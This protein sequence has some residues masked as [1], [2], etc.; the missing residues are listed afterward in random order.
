MATA[1]VSGLRAALKSFWAI[2]RVA[3][4]LTLAL[5]L[6][7]RLGVL[8]WV[9]GL[10]KP[11]MNL[12]GLPGEA[13]LA[14]LASVFCNTY[15]AAAV[16]LS[17]PLDLRT[18]TILAVMVLTAHNVFSESVAMKRTGSSATKMILMRL[19]Y[20]CAAA[21]A[22]KLLLPSYLRYSVF[23]SVAAGP[24]PSF[25]GMLAAWARAEGILAYKLALLLVAVSLAKAYLSE[26]DALGPLSRL[27]A[28]A[29]R[30]LGLSRDA[31][32]P[33]VASQVIG[34]FRSAEILEAQVKSGGL[35]PQESDLVNHCT[36][37]CHSL[38]EE[39]LLFGLLG[40]PLFW[41]TVPR[42]CMA[43]VPVWFERL[44]RRIFRRSFR[45]GTV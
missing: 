26:F 15:V 14:L 43:L 9:S 28:P 38:L 12:L 44:R 36:A 34:Y 35:K 4:P 22:F 3:I 24:R 10:A 6:L 45:V 18:A 11:F 21:F 30:L 40:I 29:M 37:I 2:V 8:P 27:L 13:V 5:A 39:T 20:A 32:L 31:S 42:L 23:S 7:D 1:L 17:L 41:L 25:L 33:W 19:G 16:A